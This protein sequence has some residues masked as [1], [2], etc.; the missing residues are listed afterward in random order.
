MSYLNLLPAA[1]ALLG[2]SVAALTN[3]PLTI[4][5][6]TVPSNFVMI[7]GKTY[8]PLA[9]VAKALDMSAMKD[10]NGYKLAAAGGANQV[11]GLTGKI[12][13][14][15]SCG[16][17]TVQ[18][19]DVVVT[20]KYQRH[21]SGGVTESGESENIVAILLKVKNATPK[22]QTIDPLGGKLTALTDTSDHSYQLSDLDGARAP[23]LLPGAAAEFALICR[24]PKDTALGDMVFQLHTYN[25]TTG[26][27]DYTFRIT[28]KRE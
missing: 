6:R 21:F 15:L 9:D 4:N 28:L 7:D 25:L 23:D 13:Q 11:N 5:G 12:G 17:F 1:V 22:L 18:I 14:T 27:K 3:G 20:T 24:V 19:T 16:T 2:G 8:V 10:G 26:Y